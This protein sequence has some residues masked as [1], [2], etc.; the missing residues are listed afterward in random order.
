MLAFIVGSFNATYDT[1]DSMVA[2]FKS[3]Q[4]L[5]DEFLAC[6]TE[7]ISGINSGKITARLRGRKK[8]AIMC[9]MTTARLKTA[10]LVEKEGI[11]IKT[12]FKAIV[13]EKYLPR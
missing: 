4:T 1:L 12:K 8:N 7:L 3:S 5:L 10:A 11:R 6:V 2:Q 9:E 13:L